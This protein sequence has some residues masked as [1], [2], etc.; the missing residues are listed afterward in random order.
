MEN[1]GQNSPESITTDLFL[2]HLYRL[3]MLRFHVHYATLPSS[4]IV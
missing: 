3:R 4:P 1:A 2:C